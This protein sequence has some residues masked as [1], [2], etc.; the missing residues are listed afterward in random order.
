MRFG[1]IINNEAEFKK[2]SDFLAKDGSSVLIRF[3]QH[4]VSGTSHYVF[5][6]YDEM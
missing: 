2:H 5:V 3:I 1:N 6:Y 4:M